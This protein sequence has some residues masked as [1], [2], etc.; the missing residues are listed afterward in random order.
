MS[1]WGK[2]RLNQVWTHKNRLGEFFVFG[3]VGTGN[4]RTIITLAERKTLPAIQDALKKYERYVGDLMND[5]PR[6]K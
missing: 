5:V 6:E 2:R 4:N 1:G 3:Q